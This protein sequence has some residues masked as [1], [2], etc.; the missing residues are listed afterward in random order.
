MGSDRF[1]IVAKAEGDVQPGPNGPVPLML[2]ALLADRFKL[3]A[4]NESRELPIY[5][6]SR[7][8]ATA[9]SVLS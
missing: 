1:D 5:A 7:R 2:R 9:S 6:P 4:H 3:T 8:G